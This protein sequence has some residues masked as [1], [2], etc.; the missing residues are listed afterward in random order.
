MTDRPNPG[1]KVVLK[2]LPP[3]LIDGLPSDDQEAIR[4]VIG[5]PIILNGYDADGR[6]ELEFTDNAKVA[7]FIYVD[8]RFIAAT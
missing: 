1:D 6:A 3:G 2:E 8:R 4:E 5:K 7:H